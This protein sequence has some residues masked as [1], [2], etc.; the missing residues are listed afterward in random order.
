MVNEM[1]V[2]WLVGWITTGTINIK[3][4]LP[5]ALDDILM[6]DYKAAVQ[7]NLAS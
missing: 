4:G 1:Y 3:T 5:F 2:A 7:E 6:P